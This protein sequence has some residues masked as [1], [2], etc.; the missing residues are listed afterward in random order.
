MIDPNRITAVCKEPF[1]PFQ[2]G[3]TY[4]ITIISDILYQDGKGIIHV[5]N[6]YRVFTIGEWDGAV[7]IT[8]RQFEDYFERP[9]EDE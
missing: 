2:T 4:P 8:P 6:T 5:P 1:P 9:E 7:D 3:V